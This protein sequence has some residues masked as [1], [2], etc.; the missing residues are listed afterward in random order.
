MNTPPHLIFRP[1]R[2]LERFS[3]GSGRR[4]LLPFTPNDSSAP[5]LDAIKETDR[6]LGTSEFGASEGPRAQ[7]CIA[8]EGGQ[9][10]R[11]KIEQLNEADAGWAF[12]G[13]PGG[14]GKEGL[15]HGAHRP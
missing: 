5:G 4:L 11:I 2:T 3:E 15:G 6:L 9:S 1:L 7:Q 14:E 10:S 13:Y 8:Q 12:L